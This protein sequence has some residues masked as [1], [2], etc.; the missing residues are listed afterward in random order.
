MFRA[1]TKVLKSDLNGLNL[2]QGVNT[3]AV[4]VLRYLVAFII[5]RMCELILKLGSC[6]QYMKDWTQS[7]MLTDFIYLKKT[8]PEVW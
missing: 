4:S 5:W 6:L 7:L 2:V 1:K 3:S 8:E